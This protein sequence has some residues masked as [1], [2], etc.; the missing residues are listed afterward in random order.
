MKPHLQQQLQF[1]TP[2]DY[3]NSNPLS[4][5]KIIFFSEYTKKVN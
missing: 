4:F 5:S 1:E 3:G 2:L